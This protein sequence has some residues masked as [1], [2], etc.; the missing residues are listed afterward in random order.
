MEWF[1][2]I[3][4]I[5]A[6]IAMIFI[7]RKKQPKTAP[8]E[9]QHKK[10]F[11]AVRIKPHEHA[12]NAAFDYSHRVYLVDEAPLL[13][14]PDCDKAETCRCGYTHYDDR[15]QG[16]QR[17]GMSFTMTDVHSKKDKRDEEKHGRRKD[18]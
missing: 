7:S 14:L 11:A 13:P 17:R 4:V 5:I 18:D 15:R 6:V 9:E 10:S 16:L 12:C 8:A 1:L 3:V 2:I